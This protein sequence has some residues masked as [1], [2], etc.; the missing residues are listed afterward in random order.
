MVARSSDQ[1]SFARSGIELLPRLVASEVT[2]LSICD[3]V[4]GRREV[5][6]VPDAAISAEDR[7]CFDRHFLGHPLVRHH[8]LGHGRDTHRISDSVPFA[9]FR[10]TAL[11]NEYYRRVGLDHA[12]ALPVYVDARLLVSF[13][14][15]RTRLDFSDR[16][17]AVLDLVRGSLAA[18]YR[19]AALAPTRQLAASAS[20]ASAIAAAPFALS[21]REREVLQWVAAGKTDREIATILGISHRTVHKHLQRIYTVLGV[22]TRTA[23]V[24]RALGLPGRP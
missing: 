24:M 2:T 20:A 12:I 21:P 7:A 6:A 14:L 4:N 9:Q 5:V 1:S 15:N 3:L 13:V 18:L 8:G 22:E 16:D 10:R 19:R 23:A 11:Y 17:R